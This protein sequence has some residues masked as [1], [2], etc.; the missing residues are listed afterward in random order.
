[1]RIPLN[2][3]QSPA[4][5]SAPRAT[6]STQASFADSLAAKRKTTEPQQPGAPGDGEAQALEDL[7]DRIE[8]FHEQIVLM[9]RLMMMSGQGP[10]PALDRE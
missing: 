4:A 5:S 3:P 10:M 8:K 6:P 1:M 2:L 7:R 9:Q